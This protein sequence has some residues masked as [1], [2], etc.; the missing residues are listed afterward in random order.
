MPKKKE[1]TWS[2]DENG[3]HNCTSHYIDYDGYPKIRKWGN[4]RPMHR[5]IYSNHY[6]NGERIQSHILVRH[7]CDNRRC[8]N[9]EHLELGTPQDNTNDMI[10]RGRK[11]CLVGIKNSQAILSEE[12]VKK[13]YF[14]KNTGTVREIANN[15]NLKRTTVSA[16]IHKHNWTYITDLL[17]NL[18]IN[19]TQIPNLEISI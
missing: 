3:C 1:I 13:I 18:S 12:M 19:N 17:D 10:S 4:Q 16:V 15:L 7:K 5:V 11:P 9:P 2:V 6:L 14:L 8:I